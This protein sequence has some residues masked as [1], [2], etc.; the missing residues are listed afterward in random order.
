[1][2][3]EAFFFCA[4]F[5]LGEKSM[6]ASEAGIF[7]LKRAKVPMPLLRNTDFSLGAKIGRI[8]IGWFGNLGGYVKLAA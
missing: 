8:K 7:C 1:M 6:S 3:P 2:V 5:L 4:L